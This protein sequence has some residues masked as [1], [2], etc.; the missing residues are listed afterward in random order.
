MVKQIVVREHESCLIRSSSLIR[1]KEY[2]VTNSVSDQLILN[3]SWN[4][5]DTSENSY[6][7]KI[8]S[9]INSCQIAGECQII[10]YHTI[11]LNN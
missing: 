6:R 5:S 2:N 11:F 8:K 3:W 9:V 4:K 1:Y 7:D 10:P